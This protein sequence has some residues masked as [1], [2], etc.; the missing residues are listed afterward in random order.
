MAPALGPQQGVGIVG[1]VTSQ[2]PPTS[3]G[4]RDC[5]VMFMWQPLSQIAT[6][7]VTLLASF[8]VSYN[9]TSSLL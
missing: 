7:S 2:A 3:S 1:G 6:L 5:N 4:V 8:P 9:S